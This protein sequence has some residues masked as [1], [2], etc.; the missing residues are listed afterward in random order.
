MDK[1]NSSQSKITKNSNN[2]ILSNEIV[3]NTKDA[4]SKISKSS[5][6][7]KKIL[8]SKINN[9]NLNQN[10]SNPSIKSNVKHVDER[11]ARSSSS[12]KTPSNTSSRPTSTKSSSS[13]VSNTPR[14]SR[15]PTGHESLK[16]ESERLESSYSTLRNE[17]KKTT[18]PRSSV[19]SAHSSHSIRSTSS[20]PIS[21]NI[22]L[23]SFS[24]PKISNNPI[25]SLDNDNDS[26]SN[27]FSNSIQS[28]GSQYAHLK[29]PSGFN[30]NPLLFPNPTP[31]YQKKII[32]ACNNGTNRELTQMVLRLGRMHQS[33]L[34]SRSQADVILRLMIENYATHE[35]I[36]KKI[37]Y[38]NP[39][40]RVDLIPKEDLFVVYN[41]RV[42]RFLTE[43][44]QEKLE[45]VNI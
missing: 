2:K 14:S 9:N 39:E 22:N 24:T 36:E 44:A 26:F 4:I 19:N 35:D 23:Q 29:Q 25:L 18:P 1:K 37:F 13:S 7:N 34:I 21:S 8:N 40:I 5:E 31:Y 12:S 15:P 11:M 41:A 10:E 28:P 45:K 43:I 3:N 16:N 27:R 30:P 33:G 42:D 6:E 38:W 20:T 32:F 17:R